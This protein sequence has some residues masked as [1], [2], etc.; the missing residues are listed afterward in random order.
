MDWMFALQS[1]IGLLAILNPF[2]A[3]P[4]FLAITED[5]Q[6]VQRRRLARTAAIAVAVTLLLF[7]LVGTRLLGFFGVGLPA[8]QVGGGILLLGVAITLLHGRVSHSKIT[9]EEAAESAEFR[10]I[11]VVPLAIP[12]LSGPGSISTIIVMSA[13]ATTLPR[14]LLLGLAVLV[15]AA[16]V[17]F[18]LIAATRLQ[19]YLGRVGIAIIGRVMGLLLAAIAVQFMADGLLALF[20]G[21]GVA[22]SPAAIPAG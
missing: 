1:T 9:E 4:V 19:D 22:P 6:P 18:V 7:M 17:F 16:A 12:M 10:S 21:L 8:F 2:G 14:Q 11:G 13:D 15:V 5:R 20:P 3:V